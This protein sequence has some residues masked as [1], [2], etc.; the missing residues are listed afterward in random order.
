MNRPEGVARWQ[1]CTDGIVTVRIKAGRR[2]IARIPSTLRAD[3]TFKRRLTFRD[4]SRF[5]GNGALT[6]TARYH[7]NTVMSAKT[8]RKVKARIR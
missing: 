5:A 7:G 2:T 8:S 6:F 4:A 3:C 1:A